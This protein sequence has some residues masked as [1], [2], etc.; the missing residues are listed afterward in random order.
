M[1]GILSFVNPRLETPIPAV[2]FTVGIIF[3]L[4]DYL[5]QGFLSLCFLILSDNVFTLINYVSIVNWFAIGVAT[6]GLLWLRKTKPPSTHPRPLQ[7][8]RVQVRIIGDSR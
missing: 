8:E 6:C 1:P 7:V 5:S 3:K 2:L 4:G